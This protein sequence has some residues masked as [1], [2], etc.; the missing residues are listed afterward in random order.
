MA[1]KKVKAG[2]I[3]KAGKALSDLIA[4]LRARDVSAGIAA[5]FAFTDEFRLAFVGVPLVGSDDKKKVCC[6]PETLDEEDGWEECALECETLQ[7]SMT[8]KKVVASGFDVM[9]IISLILKI[10]SLLK[11]RSA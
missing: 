7:E 5:L 4:A 8:A 6:V 2:D 9:S 11:S 1:K 10:M 3:S